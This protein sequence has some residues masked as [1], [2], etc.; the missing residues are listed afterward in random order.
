MVSSQTQAQQVVK[1]FQGI[2]SENNNPLLVKEIPAAAALKPLAAALAVLAITGGSLL[3]PTVQAQARPFSG[4]WMAGKGAATGQHGANRLPG[5]ST[6]ARQQQQARQKLNRSVENL[7]SAAAAIAAQQAA[8][9]A[10]RNTAQSA[11]SVLDG[12]TEGGLKVDATRPLSEAWINAN[13]PVQ[14]QNGERTNVAIEQTGDKAILNWETFNVG[15][16][17]TVDFKQQ[18]NWAALNRVN[19]PNSR[20]S[21]IQGQIKGDGTVMIANANGVVFSGSSQVNVRNLVAAAANISD[22]QFRDHGLYGA[23]NAATFTNA[24]GKIEVQRGAQITT[25]VPTSATQGGGYALLLGSDIH[26]DGQITT[27]SGQT[28]LAAGDNFFIR[29]GVGTEGNKQSTTRG[30]EVAAHLKTD[31]LSSGKVLNTGLITAATG[32]ITLT[33]HDVTQAGVA[34]ATTSTAIRGT[35][36]LL[37]S[38]SDSDGRVT[39]AQGST[40]AIVLDE[41]ITSGLDSQRDAA[42]QALDGGSLSGSHNLMATGNFDNLSTA[43]DRS[44]LSRIEIVSGNTAEFQGDSLTLATGGQI[45][46]AAKKRTLIDTGATLDVSGAVG[47]RIAMES[48]NLNINVQGNEQRDAPI[49]RDSGTLNSNDLWIDRRTLVHVAAGTNGY[50]SDRW[51]TAGGLLEVS[52]YLGTQGHSTGEWMAQGGTIMATGGELITRAGSSINL[53]GGTLD[54]QSGYLQQTWLRG[55]DGRLYEASRAPGDLLYEGLYRGYE[56]KHVRWGETA[57]RTFYNPLIG[58]R[59]RFEQGYT[60]GRDAGRFIVST[61]N[62]VLEGDI[63]SDVYQ[64][65][66]QTEKANAALADGY[67][68]SQNAVARRGQLWVGRFTPVYDK[69]TGRLRYGEA[70]SALKDVILG[71]VDNIADVLTLDEV[72]P[73]ERQNSLY[74]DADTLSS[75]NLDEFKILA[76]D[77]IQVQGALMVNHGG[78]I[79]L[80]AGAV[81][82]MADLT[83][84]S[85]SISLGNIVQ[86]YASNLGFHDAAISASDGLDAESVTVHDNVVLNAA[87]LWANLNLNPDHAAVQP[88]INGGNIAIRSRGAVT[89]NAG[90]LID[91]TSGAAMIQQGRLIGGKGGNVTLAAGEQSTRPSMLTLNGDIQGYGVNGG[92]E[93]HIASGMAVGIGSGFLTEEG[94]LRQA[95]P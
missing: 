47:V 60:V 50:E 68:Q 37:N 32:D 59:Q 1:D 5:G 29:K 78:H 24:N 66:R 38:A 48:N 85:G 46:V 17:T 79:G 64:G 62:A 51:Y 76:Q 90:S 93:L 25:H 94:C 33:G 95:K 52:G 2:S 49:N 82:V 87:G 6:A 73:E 88:F 21:Q 91:V 20:P 16:N 84:H 70:T 9:S 58:P 28:T 18:A 31:S 45:V 77:S 65:A 15:R 36:H 55:A 74:L 11:A 10:A 30:N 39:L 57:T 7:G 63:I 75:M 26:N 86:G 44:D 19:D 22:D 42:L 72:L 54:V 23:N 43:W 80:H 61:A 83:A 92:G 12:L 89:L 13:A 4:S 81:D 56:D 71:Q 40:T 34:V 35:I 69:N 3:S 41:S 53:S 8:Q 27:A 14:T 67:Y